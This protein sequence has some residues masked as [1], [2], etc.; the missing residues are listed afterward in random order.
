MTVRESI[1]L[2]IPMKRDFWFPAGVDDIMIRDEHGKVIAR[3]IVSPAHAQLMA[4]APELLTC[5]ELL[6]E[7]ADGLEATDEEQCL[8]TRC[9]EVISLLNGDPQ[10]P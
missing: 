6:L 8:I 9:K 10:L 3:H 7:C 2:N 5:L 1:Q 4:S